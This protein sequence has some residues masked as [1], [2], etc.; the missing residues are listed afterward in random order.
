ML[1]TTYAGDLKVVEQQWRL[2]FR[3]WPFK[4][5]FPTR[6]AFA[7]QA[8]HRLAAAAGLEARVRNSPAGLFLPNTAVR[9]HS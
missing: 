5:H 9:C 6:H 8:I 2:T 1:A 7:L 4:T 3:R